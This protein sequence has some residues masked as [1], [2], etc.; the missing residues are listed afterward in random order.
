MCERS[1][2]CGSGSLVCDSQRHINT[3][4]KGVG[5]EQNGSLT[6]RG[7]SNR[8]RSGV[9]A[10]RKCEDRIRNTKPLAWIAV[11]VRYATHHAFGEV[12]KL[13][14]MQEHPNPIA[15]VTSRTLYGTTGRARVLMSH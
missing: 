13:V 12:G 3:H 4:R 15:R 14:Q 5:I 6:S 2:D 7:W 11:G 8:N 10:N 9:E 1:E